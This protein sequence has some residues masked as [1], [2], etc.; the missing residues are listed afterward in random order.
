MGGGGGGG[1][2]WKGPPEPKGGGGGGGTGWRAE[3]GIEGEGV[4]HDVVKRRKS[5]GGGRLRQEDWLGRCGGEGCSWQ[6]S[7]Y[8][9]NA[10][11]C[12]CATAGCC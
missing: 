8:E 11:I 7:C 9:P 10:A 2:C 4:T 1:D 3:G 6:R 5:I 12:R